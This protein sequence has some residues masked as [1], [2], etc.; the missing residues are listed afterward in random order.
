MPF[1]IRTVKLATGAVRVEISGELDIATS[2]RLNASL[3]RELVAGR[4]VELDLSRVTFMDACALGT[5]MG[6]RKRFE[7][8]QQS[9]A[10]SLRRASQ[11]HRLLRLT[12][13]LPV[14]TLTDGA[15]P[16]PTSRV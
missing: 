13:I 12:G 5:I 4:D 1:S 9:F 14:L 15:G 8:R 3:L 11:P 10:V 7:L 2:P 6:A 16:S